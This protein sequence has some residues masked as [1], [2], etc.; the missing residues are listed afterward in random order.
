MCR[1][2]YGKNAILHQHGRAKLGRVGASM[3]YST[4]SPPRALATHCA[5]GAVLVQPHSPVS[6]RSQIALA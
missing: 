2:F 3:L 5:Y 4:I 1:I 6:C